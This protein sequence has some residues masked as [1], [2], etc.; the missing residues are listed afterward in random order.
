MTTLS[1]KKPARRHLMSAARAARR[2]LPA[3]IPP[4][5]VLTDPG[6]LPASQ[7]LTL[8]LPPGW[9]VIYRHFGADTRIDEARAVRAYCTRRRL[10]CLIANDPCLAAAV[11]ADGLHWPERQA[12]AARRWTDRFSI[13]TMSWH[14][15]RPVTHAPLGIDAVLV[16]TVFPSRSPTAS[17]AMGARRFRM[18]A[19]KSEPPIF[20]LGGV[21]PATAGKIACVAGL[22]GIEGFRCFSGP[23]QHRSSNVETA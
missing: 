1:S 16:S 23:A 22:A 14:A 7:L 10:T 2:T 18:L 17:A 9:G 19:R 3:N 5:F 4:A 20:G 13:M 11:G 8:C 15:A 12:G 6:R 21:T